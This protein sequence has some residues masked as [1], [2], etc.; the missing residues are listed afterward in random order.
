MGG[1]GAALGRLQER[2]AGEGAPNKE[3]GDALNKKSSGD[4]KGHSGHIHRHENGKH[5][6]TVHDKQ[7]QLVHHSEHGSWNEAA[8]ELGQHG[9]GGAGEPSEDSQPGAGL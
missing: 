7:G 1:L 5:H 8:Q 6:V 3:P 4:H 2:G 9:A